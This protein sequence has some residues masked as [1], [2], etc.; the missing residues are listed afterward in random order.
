MFSVFQ[1][2]YGTLE[3]IIQLC[4]D[5]IASKLFSKN[6]IPASVMTE[7]ITGPY[8]VGKKASTLLV[9]V[10]TQLQ[11]NPEKVKHFIDVLREE[12]SFDHITEA[13]QGMK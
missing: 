10:C 13:M 12:P 11:A 9:H 4:P 7:V 1:H 6:L 3:T 2:H 5:T 8:S